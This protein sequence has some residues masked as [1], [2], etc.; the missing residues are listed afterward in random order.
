MPPVPLFER[1]LLALQR[2]PLLFA[3]LAWTAVYALSGWSETRTMQMEYARLGIDT[4]RW[5]IPTWQATSAL[6]SLVLV[7]L[8]GWAEGRWPLRW[9]Q[10]RRHLVCH[11]G[12][13][14]AYSLLHV[15]GMVAMR[16]VIYAWQGADYDF[17]DWPRELLYEY[18]K[19]ARSY[20]LL[21][22]V[23]HYSRSLMR[24]AQGEARLLDEPDVDA[25]PIASDAAV[26]ATA[27]TDARPPQR[28]VVRKLGRE[29]IVEAERIEAALASGNYANLHAG[30]AV[31][32]LRSTLAQLE[33]QLD[34]ERFLRVHRSAIVRID[35]IASVAAG[36]GGEASVQM[37]SG[38]VVPCSRRYRS[39]LKDRIKG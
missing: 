22:V 23:F 10:L 20:A 27:P 5:E 34:A 37:R 31:Y 28:F 30:G 15:I 11:A 14:V 18:L 36:E 17:G 8:V 9:G 21:V 3:A 16:E 29:F 6:S 24:L 35:A 26:T 38:L 4:D 32:P 33:T 39:R 7:A 1:W 13:S 2:R 12:L 25:L 19:D